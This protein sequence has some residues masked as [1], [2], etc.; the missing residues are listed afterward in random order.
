MWVGKSHSASQK[1]PNILW[2]TKF[3]Y[4]VHI[5]P[6]LLPIVSQ[7]YPVHT[8][9]PYYPMIHFNIIFPSMPKFSEWSL[10]FSF[11]NKNIVSIYRLSH[12]CFIPRPSH[13]PWFDH[14]NIICLSV[15][16]MKLHIMQSSPASL[17][18]SNILPST[19]FSYSLNLCSFL[20]VR[21]QV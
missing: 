1:I 5:S 19:L 11:F 12:A 3:Y 17:L 4:R 9:P 10:P 15:Q 6:P 13:S 16:F 20:G 21:D 8:F 2:N 7:M 18:S 14:P